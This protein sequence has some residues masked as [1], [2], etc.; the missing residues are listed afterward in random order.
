MPTKF[1][2]SLHGDLYNVQINGSSESSLAERSFFIT[3]D[4]VPEEVLVCA[5]DGELT[6]VKDKISSRPTASDE[7]DV[8]VAMPSTVVSVNV[9]QGDVVKA[10]DV[11]L[12][13]EAMKMETEI[14]APISGT[15]KAVNCQKN[16]LVNPKEALIE[17]S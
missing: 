14:Q 12:V 9:S 3:L 17:L 10:G 2:V 6:H 5:L 8:T 15:V 1:D 16:D 7:G 11:L 13:T 4:G